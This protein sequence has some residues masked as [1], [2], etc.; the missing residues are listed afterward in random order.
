M[1]WQFGGL[2]SNEDVLDESIMGLVSL[3]FHSLLVD[4]VG[5]V[6][7]D[8]WVNNCD[9][10]SSSIVDSLVQVHD[11][12]LAEALVVELCVLLLLSMVNVKP[13]NINRESISAKVMVTFDHVISIK[14]L[15]FAEVISERVYGWHWSVSSQLREFLL[16]VLWR[17]LSSQEIELKSISL[18]DEG[19]V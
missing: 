12:L 4:V 1:E 2:V 13:E 19:I 3:E 8:M 18:R 15:V 9:E 16:E 6:S 11:L 7:T 10:S 14:F 17:G 5:V